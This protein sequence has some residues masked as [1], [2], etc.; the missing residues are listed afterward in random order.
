MPECVEAR[1]VADKLRPYLVSRVITNYYTGQRAKTLGFH[2]LQCPATI[3]A[4]RSYGKKVLIDLD[5]KHCIVISLGMTGRLQMNQGNHSHVRFDIC[6]F[7][8]LNT[9]RVM[10]N[11]FSLY[12][13]DQRYMGKIDVILDTDIQ[14]YFKDVGPD[15]LQN[16]LDE[17]TWITLHDWLKIFYERKS[18]RKM[19][20]ILL[21]QTL[22]AGIGWYLM[23]DI[24]YYSMIH[25]E[26]RSNTLTVDEWD[27]VR[28]NS[29]KVVVLSYSYGGF[30]IK[31]FIS[32]DGSP[33]LYPAAIYG[34]THDSLGNIV[35]HKKLNNGRT[36]H[37][38]PSIQIIL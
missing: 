34:K 16:A 1:T 4:V 30:T 9:M 23:T 19:Y 25:P 36:A 8:Y 35:H 15:L 20:D 37:F 38:V 12:F 22:I 10:K 24:L 33:G 5:T 32:P 14:T 7:Y 21:D 26:R 31:D 17:K 27:R 28:I 2:N 6:D 3:T 29:H 18:K 11:M 13:E